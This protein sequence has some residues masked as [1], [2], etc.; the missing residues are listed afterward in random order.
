[1]KT[2]KPSR[3]G[4]VGASSKVRVPDAAEYLRLLRGLKGVGEDDYAMFADDAVPTITEFIPTGSL[5]IDKLINGAKGGWPIGGI[6]ECAAWEHVGKSTL[7]DQSIAH[8]QRMGGIAFLIDSE[9][10]RDREWTEL[11]GV[12]ASKVITYQAATLEDAFLGIEQALSVQATI[13][14]DLVKKKMEPPPMLIVWDSLG[15]TPSKAELEGEPDDKHM[16]V[17]ARVIKMN[18][19]RLTQRLASL[20]CALVFSNHF[21]NKIGGYGGLETYGGSGVKYHTDV[22]LW[23]TKPEKLKIGEQEIGHVIR[24]SGKKNR[25]SG[26]RGPVDTALIYGAGVDNAYTLF[27]WGRTAKNRDGQAWI[28]RNGAWYWVYPPGEDPISFQRL[29]LGL[30]EVFTS[31]SDVY[32]AMATQYLEAPW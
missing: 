19:R 31:R 8:C 1:M 16:A 14:D 12:D 25:I 30:G 27:E 20:R 29:S 26:Q 6:S 32:Q 7:L 2:R 23:L 13:R 24:A 17:A 9:K 4:D 10:G 28:V 3:A 22:R 5:A 18:F 15:G 11:L 21:Y